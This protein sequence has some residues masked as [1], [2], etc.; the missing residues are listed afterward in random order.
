MIDF[1]TIATGLRFPEGPIA[2]PDGDVLVVEILAGQLTRIAPNGEKTVVATTGGG[3]N[4]AAIGP[5]GC[6]YCSDLNRPGGLSADGRQST[7]WSRGDRA[8]DYID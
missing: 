6:C 7:P 8:A 1:H 2:L 4:G 3:P 5:D